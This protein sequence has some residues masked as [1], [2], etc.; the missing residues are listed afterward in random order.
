[1]ARDQGR[2]P[3]TQRIIQVFNEA[4]N[5]LDESEPAIRDLIENRLMDV[6]GINRIKVSDAVTAGTN[7]AKEIAAIRE[8]H[9]KRAFRHLRD[10][11]PSDI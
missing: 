1:M 4:I 6:A 5:H 7:L 10:N 2:D 8:Q 3:H 11:L 9:L